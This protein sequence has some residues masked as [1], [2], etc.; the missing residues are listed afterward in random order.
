MLIEFRI[1]FLLLGLCGF[2]AGETIRE[3]PAGVQELHSPLEVTG[4]DVVLR[5]AAGGTTL[6]FAADF[7]GQ[8][9][10]IARGHNL[11]I[12]RLSIDGSRAQFS[13]RLG[14]PPYDKTF[15]SF[16]ALTGVLADGVDG[17]FMI[18]V[19]L[20][21]MPAMAVIVRGG[22]GIR[23]TELVVEDSGGLNDKAR[24]NA[25]GGVLLEDG[26]NDFT[27][28]RC[29]FRRIRGN[30]LWTH[31]RYTATRNR[32]GAFVDNS[33]EEIGRD[34]IQIGHASNVKV[35]GNRG[36]R[37][38]YPPDIVDAEGGGTPV[39]I[40]TAGNVDFS[41]YSGNTFE[42]LNG[43]CIDLDGFHHGEVSKNI[44]RNLKPATEYAFGHFGIVMNN[45]NPDMQSVAIVITGNRIEGMKYGG[46]FVIG[47]GHTITGNTLRHLNTAHCS[48]SGGG[49]TYF[50]G[51][52][53]LL[54]T[55]IYFGRRAERAAAT[56]G[57]RI[58]DNTISG[59][60]MGERCFGFAPGVAKNEQR[61]GRNRCISEAK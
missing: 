31:S 37:I 9:A 58:D 4:D 46:I 14:L 10:V 13:Q 56:R 35:T 26:V 21:N 45:T 29:T 34:A 51:E 59:W 60:K 39:G 19:T 54:R 23:L 57:N 25:T 17:F 8:A 18:G 48:E 16:H 53:D 12:E 36:A 1:P 47:A 28:E 6:R 7:A 55:G 20:R 44:C 24:N 42:E 22:R 15:A 30:A 38:G 32:N 49:C 11:R 52:P 43:K 33:F 40:D 3:L 2:L 5:G 41:I 50:A 27:V 61:I